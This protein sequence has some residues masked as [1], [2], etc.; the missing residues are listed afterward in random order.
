MRAL[1]TGLLILYG[2]VTFAG[3]T[4][5][6][7]VVGAIRWDAWTGG[8][9]TEQVERTLGPGKYHDRLPWFAKVVDE[10]TV[11]IDGSRQAIM[12][13]EIAFAVA[14]GL[15]YW[16]FLVYP[17]DSSMSVAFRQ[18]L[19]SPKRNQI[20][21][22]V[23]L[24]NTLNVTDDQWPRERDRAVALLKE[25]GYQTVLNGRPLVYAFAGKAFPFA[26]FAEFL[27]AAR[28]EGVTPYCVYMGWNPVSD[29]ER[30]SKTGFQAVSAYA[31]SGEQDSFTNL[32]ESMEN[33]WQKAAKAQVPYVPLVTTGWDKRP[34]QDHPVS[35]EINASYHTQKV[36]PS[37]ATSEEIS[38]H[39]GRAVSF[40]KDNSRICEANA[41]IIY[42]WN[43]YDEG[44]WIAPTRG[45][46]GK[47]D[48]GRIDAVRKILAAMSAQAQPVA[49][50]A[51]ASGSAASNSWKALA[52]A[53]PRLFFSASDL[54]ALR[55]KARSSACFTQLVTFAEAYRFD[56]QPSDS[57][58]LFGNPAMVAEAFLALMTQEPRH[59][60][61][62]KKQLLQA[63]GWE[64]DIWR[65]GVTTNCGKAAGL[66]LGHFAKSVA[67]C[68][69]WL[70]PYMSDNERTVVRDALATKAFSIYNEGVE[71]G[72]SN[73]WWLRS[74]NNWCPVIQG[75]VGIAALATL[76]EVPEAEWILGQTRKRLHYYLDPFPRDGGCVE[77]AMYGIYGVSNA[78][79]FGTALQHVTGTDDN[80]LEHP[81][82]RR[83][84]SFLCSFTG[85]DNAWVNFS[86]CQTL[87]DMHGELYPLVAP[88]H[89]RA[90]DAYL[91]KYVSKGRRGLAAPWEI[92]F[93]PADMDSLPVPP[94]D[95][96][97]VFPETQWAA[98]R[99][100]KMQ[101]FFKSGNIGEG[102][103]HFDLNTF[104]LLLNGERLVPTAPY[105]KTAT[106]FHSTILVNGQ[107]QKW[108][109]KGTITASGRTNGVLFA[110]AEAG[111]AYGGGLS[112]FRRTAFLVPDR[113]A[114][115]GD[116]LLGPAGNK[117]EWKLQT[118]E[119]PLIAPDRKSARINGKQAALQVQVV[120]PDQAPL[121]AGT[122]FGPCLSADVTN[123]EAVASY[124][125]L[126]AP[127]DSLVSAQVVD[128][129][130]QVS[131]A[132]RVYTFRMTDK[133]WCAK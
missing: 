51:A 104:V 129:E 31:K 38:A 97:I 20:R 12:D 113:F 124:F 123:A 71:L 78:G 80:I 116:V 100:E 115:I 73:E 84:G 47:P 85:A 37:R 48:T 39:L 14:A 103:K 29:S 74:V 64:K 26:R 79:L 118:S 105:G 35:W 24:H 111:Q 102:H 82:I 45:S 86:N 98:M 43:E 30:V 128:C 72:E 91:Q 36:F 121:S 4:R 8:R 132:N 107:G 81:G 70:Y 18:Y 21:F 6:S 125:V 60:E 106:G 114:A 13:Q 54:P 68:Y 95:D 50:P 69:D 99:S 5:P 41:I 92:I 32:V 90:L 15:E 56:E 93:R 61:K 94:V 46:D 87:I 108:N 33:D 131:A 110:T 109:S 75:G 89:D 49:Q 1:L 11:Q 96:L 7:P 9:V 27:A 83:F 126:L 63:A 122:S 59:I 34:R 22:C 10:K 127:A 88:Y 3:E 101:L 62:A 17:E 76:G 133:G 117:Y 19:Q 23:I 42:A 66:G 40:I 119:T 65:G 77:G 53:H 2:A 58:G 25:P 57:R 120:L 67:I 28:E 112:T 52:G 44:G 130:V 16:A 55:A